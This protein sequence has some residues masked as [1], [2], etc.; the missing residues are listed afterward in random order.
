MYSQPPTIRLNLERMDN[1]TVIN[2]PQGLGYTPNILERKKKTSAI[3]SQGTT[4]RQAVKRSSNQT[5][6]GS[7]LALL[8]RVPVFLSAVVVLALALR[9]VVV[10]FAVHDSGHTIHDNNFGW[11]SWEMGW[12]A[13]SLYL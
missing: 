9:L 12:T 8:D 2:P 10:F 4:I 3:Q 5:S 11:E 13:R 1:N 7:L 6:P